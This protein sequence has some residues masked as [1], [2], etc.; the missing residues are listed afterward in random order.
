MRIKKII[1]AVIL[2]GIGF[3]LLYVFFL[4]GNQEVPY[5]I[6]VEQ[7][8]FEVLIASQGSEFKEALVQSVLKHYESKPINFKVIDAYTLFTVNIDKWDAVVVINSWEYSTPPF[9]IK[10]FIKEQPNNRDKLII[11]S[12]VG[13]YNMA[14]EEVDT[15]SG[16]SIIEKVP[17]YSAILVDRLDA[18]LTRNKK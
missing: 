4:K 17:E 12:T 2:L 10:K 6:T 1:V 14:L 11:L 18:I 16:E 8:K 5:T 15:I 3:G 7:P 13:S 9:N